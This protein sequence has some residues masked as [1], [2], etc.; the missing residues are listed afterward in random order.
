MIR[1]PIFTE[2]TVANYGLF[3]GVPGGTNLEWPF[4]PGLTLITG[5]NGLG[6]TTLL[7][8]LLRSLTGPFD[9]T[10]AGVPEQLEAVLPEAPVALNSQS[11]RFFAQRVADGADRATAT[12]TSQ[13][14]KQ[15]LRIERRLNDLTL[16]SLSVNRKEA[17]LPARR[18]EKEAL[19]QETICNLFGLGSFVDVLLILHHIVF[20]LENRPGA[21][22]DENAQRQILR[23]LLLDKNLAT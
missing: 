19:F 23:A 15:V 7:T 2:L 5:V 11:L 17:S 3:T 12:L 4:S 6:K 22:W 21:L 18:G 1:L 16:L 10:S 20:F 9:L 14:G 13:F 8:I